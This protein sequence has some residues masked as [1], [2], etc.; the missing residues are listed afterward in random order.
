M[1]FDYLIYTR[2]PG[3][4]ALYSSGMCGQWRYLPHRVQIS[5]D[6]VSRTTCLGPDK[7]SEK[8]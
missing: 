1:M 7:S 2:K 8:N 4:Y 6:V 5:G 3:E